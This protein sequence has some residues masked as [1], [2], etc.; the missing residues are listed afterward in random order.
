LT[1]TSGTPKHLVHSAVFRTA[2]F[3]ADTVSALA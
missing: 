1:A 3:L 2:R